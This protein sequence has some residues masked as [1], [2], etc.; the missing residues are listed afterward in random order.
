MT[1]STPQKLRPALIGGIALGVASAIP[2]L[3]FANCFCCALVIGGGALASW[4]YLKQVPPGGQPPYGDAAILGLMTGCIGAIAG[5]LAALPFNLMMGSMGM[6]DQVQEALETAE[7]PPEMAE[8]MSNLASGEMT[9]PIIFFGMFM[10]LIIDS[11]FAT[12][13][14]LIGVAVFYKKAA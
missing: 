7:L 13:G 3:N 4:L 11:I 14:A 1:D 9:F 6:M 2:I 12:I 10:N 8:I 5:T